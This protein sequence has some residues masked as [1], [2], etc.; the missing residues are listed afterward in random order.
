M[1]VGMAGARA[2]VSTSAGVAA[3]G[4]EVGRG[5]CGGAAVGEVSMVSAGLEV[6][7]LQAEAPGPIASSTRCGTCSPRSSSSCS[8]L[9]LS[10]RSGSG[11]RSTASGTAGTTGLASSSPSIRMTKP[12][13][14]RTKKPSMRRTP[15]PQHHWC[16][17][18]AASAIDKYGP[19][20]L[21]PVGETQSVA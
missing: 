9:V 3:D 10:S 16:S 7:T 19:G 21:L 1:A 6:G 18:A 20:L 8:S 14:R 4:D 17:G 5:L 12:S 13:K 11:S 15:W 2:A